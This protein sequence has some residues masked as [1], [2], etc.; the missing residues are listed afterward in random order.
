[1]HITSLLAELELALKKRWLAA[2]KQREK[3]SPCIAGPVVLLWHTHS[4]LSVPQVL[5]Q[6]I[7]EA[8]KTPWGAKMGDDI[9]VFCQ[10]YPDVLLLTSCAC[11]LDHQPFFKSKAFLAC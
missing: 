9:Q 1:M 6:N 5:Q 8:S 7:S 11:L 4:L 10:S 3:F 2:C